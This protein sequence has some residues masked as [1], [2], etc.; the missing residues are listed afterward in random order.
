MVVP[1]SRESGAPENQLS[2]TMIVRRPIPPAG[3]SASREVD[4]LVRCN[5]S[6][7]LLKSMSSI[8]Q[9]IPV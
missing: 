9:K 6:N 1:E 5:H 4:T 7:E 8:T 2:Q 3:R